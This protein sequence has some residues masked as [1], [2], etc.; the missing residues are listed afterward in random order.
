M[1]AD[2][3]LLPCP[4]C[5]QPLEDWKVVEGSTFRWRQVDGCC[6]PGPEVRHHTLA[7][8]QEAAERQSTEDAIT[9]W[10]TRAD[11][12]GRGEAVRAVDDSMVERYCHAVHEYL[13]GLSEA[14]WEMDRKDQGAAVRRV[15]RIGLQAAMTPPPARQGDEGETN[16]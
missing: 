11:A 6:T 14:Q 16:G 1:T 4:W 15:A 3:E 8:D 7:E 2:R 13:G 5:G 12:I 9:A 10:N